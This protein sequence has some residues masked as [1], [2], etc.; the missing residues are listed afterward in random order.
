MDK[1]SREFTLH[2]T[3]LFFIENGQRLDL[4]FNLCMCNYAKPFG[5]F[6][7][8][9]MNDTFFSAL[10]IRDTAYINWHYASAAAL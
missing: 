9:N 2:V 8:H 10:F 5:D 6:C 1:I 3:M 7:E 4:F